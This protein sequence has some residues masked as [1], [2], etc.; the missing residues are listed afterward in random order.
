MSMLTKWPGPK[1]GWLEVE[2]TFVVD[3]SIGSVAEGYLQL[4]SNCFGLPSSGGKE[5][6]NKLEASSH[7]TVLEARI[8]FISHSI[9]PIQF[10]TTHHACPKEGHQTV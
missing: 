2:G 3:A 10:P 6:R 1:S 9:H 5:V 7:S 8:G 4:S